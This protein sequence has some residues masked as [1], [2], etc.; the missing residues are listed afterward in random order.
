[1]TATATASGTFSIGGDLEV[2]RLGYGA[3]RITGKG[4]WGP[5]PDHDAAL[6]VLRRLPE[7]GVDF[8]DTADSYG[9]HVSEELI[10]RG[11]PPLRRRSPSPPRPA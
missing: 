7:L 10:A 8:I 1:M 4:I 3:M 5:P 2:T 11:A 6:A 9:P